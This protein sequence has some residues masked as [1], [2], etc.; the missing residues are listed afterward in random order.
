MPLSLL[1]A[2]GLGLELPEHRAVD[3]H[4]HPHGS[5]GPHLHESGVHPLAPSSHAPAVTNGTPPTLCQQR[6]H[7]EGSDGQRARVAGPPP[8]RREPRVDH[9]QREGAE[10]WRRS[11]LMQ[12]RVPRRPLT[13]RAS[14]RPPFADR[15]GH[16]G[17]V[18]LVGP[19]GGAHVPPPALPAH[20]V[21]RPGH[22]RRAVRRRRP[23]ALLRPGH[24]LACRRDLG[25][26]PHVGVP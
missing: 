4:R 1:A 16:G 19:V 10:S 18:A 15:V 11:P 5:M 20:R 8:R 14:P 21:H 12:Q 22:R 13:H 24:H 7:L 2:E 26:V 25:P 6:G 3:P 23:R 17:P 9:W